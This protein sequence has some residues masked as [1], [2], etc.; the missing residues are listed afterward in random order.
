[1]KV[2]GLLGKKLAH[3]F[4]PDYFNTKFS[5][6][7][8]EAVYKTFEF[9]SVENFIEYCKQTK[10]LSGFNVTI[11]FKQEIVKYLTYKSVEVEKT[12]SCNTVKIIDGEMHGFNTD[13]FG[14]EKS[15]V[16][17][18]DGTEKQALIIGNG[19]AAQS[20]KFVLEKLGIR[21]EIVTRRTD[22]NFDYIDLNKLE[23][24]KHQI[25]INT[26]PVGM[27]PDINN[28]PSLDYDGIS[29]NHLCIDLIYNPLETLFLEKCRKMGAK[30]LNGLPMLRFQADKAAEIWGF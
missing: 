22:D 25:L 27:F 18:L 7:K 2:Y 11:P 28:C 8:I 9:E 13:I 3:S 26:T 21:F 14:F 4:S 19:G 30:T 12:N 24:S 16:E 15:I 6:N 23:I 29:P 5:A 20:V 10:D 17:N 1:M